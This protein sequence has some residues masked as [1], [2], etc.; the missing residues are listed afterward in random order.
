MTPETVEI[1]ATFQI[2]DIKISRFRWI[3][4]R[5][6][7]RRPCTIAERFIMTSFFMT[8]IWENAKRPLVSVGTT[9][10]L[11]IEI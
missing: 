5:Q 1:A 4:S 8:H 6:V 2:R 9:V 10:R 11:R 7:G 3:I